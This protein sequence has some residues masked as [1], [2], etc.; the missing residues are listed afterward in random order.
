MDLSLWLPHWHSPYVWTS[1][2]GCYY[3]ETGCSDSNLCCA[4]PRII[5]PSHKVGRADG[6]LWS[7]FQQWRPICPMLI[8]PQSQEMLYA[9]GVFK[10][11][12]SLTGQRKMLTF[13]GRRSASSDAVSGWLMSIRLQGARRKNEKGTDIWYPAG[14]TCF[15]VELWAR[16]ICLSL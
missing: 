9:P 3:H 1:S 6:A 10:P 2:S 15:S 13:L 7:W 11:I 16:R 12:S 5:S 14:L 8:L 4:Q